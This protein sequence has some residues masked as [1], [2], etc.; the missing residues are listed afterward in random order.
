MF[1]L[2][3]AA[4]AASV[5]GD[6]SE[7][8]RI[9]RLSAH[10]QPPPAQMTS[11]D[12]GELND[13]RLTDPWKLK[14]YIKVSPPAGQCWQIQ[15]SDQRK[16]D[17]I[18]KEQ[19][20]SWLSSELHEDGSVRWW[21]KTKA[22]DPGFFYIWPTPHRTAQTIPVGERL[23]ELHQPV[24]LLEC[25]YERKEQRKITLKMLGGKQ[26]F[27]HL[28]ETDLLIKESPQAKPNLY[29]QGSDTGWKD[30]KKVDVPSEKS[31][32][33]VRARAGAAKKEAVQSYWTLSE[34]H[35][36]AMPASN[37]YTSDHPQ[38]QHGTCRYR[39]RR[40]LEVDDAYMECHNTSDYDVVF[41]AL[42]CLATAI[43]DN[44][45]KPIESKP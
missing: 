26:W 44:K 35:A 20:L 15:R 12:E 29:I 3:T 14:G 5:F 24:L 2:G 18:C 31:L 22:D 19:K 23:M 21:I 38:G 25:V 9:R 30:G 6:L 16:A 13:P 11:L 33:A 32:A 10:I 40:G 41:L 45:A 8:E 1:W 28:P 27:I 36:F 7:D 42:P 37:F 4:L 43:D 34:E 39:K 17:L